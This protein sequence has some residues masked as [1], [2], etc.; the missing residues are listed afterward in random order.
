M[1]FGGNYR[2]ID[3]ALDWPRVA[4]VGNAPEPYLGIADRIRAGCDRVRQ[5]FDVTVQAVINDEHVGRHDLPHLVGD[6][7]PVLYTHYMANLKDAN[8][9][10]QAL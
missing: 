8:F 4:D 3:F 1:P 7:G 2:L 10:A 5:R 6:K 9:A